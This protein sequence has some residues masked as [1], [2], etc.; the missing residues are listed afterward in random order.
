MKIIVLC[1][2]LLTNV[3]VGNSLKTFSSIRLC[4]IDG[5]K[6]FGWLFPSERSGVT[7]PSFHFPAVLRGP[8]FDEIAASGW[9]A[10]SDKVCF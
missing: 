7:G 8:R 10:V 2:L 3:I 9:A 5:R 4:F 1:I 6:W